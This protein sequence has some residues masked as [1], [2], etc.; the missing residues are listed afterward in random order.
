VSTADVSIPREAVE[1]AARA[2]VNSGVVPGKTWDELQPG[3]KFLWAQR[4]KRML[5]AAAPPIVAEKSAQ[6]EDLQ[7]RLDGARRALTH[8]MPA[9]RTAEE[10]QA[11]AGAIRF[12]WGPRFAALL[13][14]LLDEDDLMAV[15]AAWETLLREQVVARAA[16]EAVTSPCGAQS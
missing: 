11:D 1:L 5:D 12:G 4:A 15:L 6:I 16:L 7:T 10:V 3:A 2:L 9:A 8:V 13:E 14:D